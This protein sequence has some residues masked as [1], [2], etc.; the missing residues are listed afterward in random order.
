MKWVFR[1][2]SEDEAPRIRVCLGG[3]QEV[4]DDMLLVAIYPLSAWPTTHPT[5]ATSS[6]EADLISMDEGGP[7]GFG[8]KAMM[9]EVGCEF[10]LDVVRMH[11]VSAVVQSL[12]AT[13]RLGK[14]RHFE[15]ML[16]W[17][18]T[19][20]VRGR[21]NVVKAR[22][23]RQVVNAMAKYHD[24]RLL[25]ALFER[26]GRVVAPTTGDSRAEGRGGHTDSIQTDISREYFHLY[27]GCTVLRMRYV[28]LHCALSSWTLPFHSEFGAASWGADRE[29]QHSQ[30][31]QLSP[32]SSGDRA[33]EPRSR[34]ELL[35][36]AGARLAERLDSSMG[37]VVL[38]APRHREPSTGRFPPRGGH[39]SRGPTFRGGG[40]CR[41]SKG[42]STTF[43]WPRWA[44]RRSRTGVW[45][46]GTSCGEVCGWELAG[47][48]PAW[49]GLRLRH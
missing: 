25:E 27:H 8:T 28:T 30:V 42:G 6:G 40:G 44:S 9:D 32:R 49:L 7:R 5:I 18:Q 14:M 43:R 33:E 13:R 2:L 45:A 21:L 46:A 37:D 3:V 36:A 12:A 31:A 17:L 38:S 16:L 19:C 11:T 1:E 47:S 29:V 41:S 23:A 24:V 34:L 35:D 48:V 39:P 22:R 15:V 26:H 4:P 20:V 10:Q